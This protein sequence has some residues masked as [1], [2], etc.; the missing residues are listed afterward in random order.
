MSKRKK[1]HRKTG[2]TALDELERELRAHG[3]PENTKYIRRPAGESK[4][5]T[6]FSEFIDPFKR[7]A[8]TLDA[9]EKLVVLG[10]CAWNAGVI[11]Q[12]E[13]QKLMEEVVQNV[14]GQAG[15]E[16]RR[17]LNFILTSLLKRKEQFFA[18]D[19]R[20]IVSYH[21]EDSGASY[22]LSMVSTTL[23]ASAK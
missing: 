18:G 1:P 20:Y 15:E 19:Q 12:A 7:Y 5:S 2:Q 23:D 6:V 16:W 8:T 11:P 4:I 13:R 17:D 3:L 14:L 21:L 22:H 9:M 10:I